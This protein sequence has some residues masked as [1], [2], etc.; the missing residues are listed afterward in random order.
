MSTTIDYANWPMEA[1]N[2]LFEILRTMDDEES[3]QQA[4]ALLEY[5]HL[6]K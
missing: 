5:I 1:L 6:H 2:E 4:Q 3:K